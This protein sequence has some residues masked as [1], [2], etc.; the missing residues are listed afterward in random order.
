[1]GGFHFD[2]ALRYSVK[3]KIKEKRTERG[4]KKG[5]EIHLLSNL[6]IEVRD[7]R[8]EGGETAPALTFTD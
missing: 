3:S 5:K 7:K 2:L 1:V 4:G 8:K 6:L